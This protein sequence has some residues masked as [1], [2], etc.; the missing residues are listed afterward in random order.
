MTTW[1]WPWMA[2]TSRA[3][4]APPSVST[5]SATPVE[6]IG[7]RRAEAQ[8]PA[9]VDQRHE[10]VADGD[11]PGR[12]PPRPCT[13]AGLGQQR[14]DDGGQRHDQRLAARP[15]TT[16]PSSTARVSGRLMVKVEPLPGREAMEM[17]PPSA[18]I[19][20]LTTS[21]PTPRPEMS[22]TV[23]RRSRSPAGRS[24]CRSPRRSAARRR[25]SGPCRW[26]SSRTVRRLMPAPS[27]A[28]SMTMRPERCGGRQPH[29]A[30]RRLAR[31]EARFRRSPG[32]GRWRCG[33][34]G[35]ADRRAAR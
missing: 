10:A 2:S 7:G 30:F 23:G 5:S 34:C 31:G 11:A 14:L 18:W 4:R 13:S 6:R 19:E 20:R 29:D 15:T 35:S 24:G 28:T 16:M 26:R 21:M 9:D 33:S 17:R 27:S 3:L 22:E 1:R 12:R 25:R 8:R 32:R